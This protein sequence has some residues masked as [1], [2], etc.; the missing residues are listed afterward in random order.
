MDTSAR[1][2]TLTMSEVRVAKPGPRKDPVIRQ[3]IR[4][5]LAKGMTTREIAREL[6]YTTQ[7]IWRLRKEIEA[8]QE[9]GAA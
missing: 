6:D 9:A 5:R 8:E 3:L 1:K 4:E 7:R 2:L